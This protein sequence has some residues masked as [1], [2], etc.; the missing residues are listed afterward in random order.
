MVNPCPLGTFNRYLGAKTS[1]Y[2]RPCPIGYKCDNLGSVEPTLCPPGHYC[3]SS[4]SVG[5]QCPAGTFSNSRGLRKEEECQQCW[6]G[7]YCQTTGL[8]KPTEQC[9][10]GFYCNAGATEASPAGA[11][12]PKH[13]YCERGTALPTKCSPGQYSLATGQFD[14]SNCVDCTLGHWCS[15]QDDPAPCDPGY[16]CEGGST[17]PKEKVAQVGYFA[18]L[19]ASSQSQCTGTDYNFDIAQS[20]CLTCPDGYFCTGGALYDCYTQ[21]TTGNTADDDYNQYCVAGV[22]SKCSTDGTY[23]THPN[24]QSAAFCVPCLEG[25]NCVLGGTPLVTSATLYANAAIWDFDSGTYGWE[26]TS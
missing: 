15:G 5:I 13:S 23:N 2:C 14:S 16:Y 1:D 25:F 22:V 19:A 6:A 21:G 9:N 4:T 26:G 8:T 10:A 11:D 12:C 17:T 20:S 7:S 24:A 3:P 18:G